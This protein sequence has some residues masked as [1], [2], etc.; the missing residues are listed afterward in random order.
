MF[1]VS[2]LKCSF[3]S[4]SNYFQLYKYCQACVFYILKIHNETIPSDL[5]TYGRKMLPNIDISSPPSQ[6]HLLGFPIFG[7]LMNIDQRLSLQCPFF[8]LSR[9]AFA[10][11][12]ACSDNRVLDLYVWWDSRLLHCSVFSWELFDSFFWLSGRRLE[13][14]YIWGGLCIVLSSK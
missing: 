7:P 9:I 1:W 8:F 12:H 11:F 10:L 13:S 5:H 2:S 4:S 14:L 3:L 6:I